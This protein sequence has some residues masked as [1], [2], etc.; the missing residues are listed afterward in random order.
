MPEELNAAVQTPE[1]IMLG[2]IQIRKKQQRH[3]AARNK[4]R[5]DLKASQRAIREKTGTLMS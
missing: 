2:E 4:S 1:A 3:A 5:P